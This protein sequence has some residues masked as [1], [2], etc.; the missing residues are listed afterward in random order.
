MLKNQFVILN[1]KE[2]YVEP[3]KTLEEHLKEWE[4]SDAWKIKMAQKYN[5]LSEEQVQKMAEDL[6]KY[7]EW[8]IY[9]SGY[10]AKG[11]DR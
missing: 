3:E 9:E 5:H 11:S 10:Y 6:K 2:P 7:R 8:Y 4:E 1:E